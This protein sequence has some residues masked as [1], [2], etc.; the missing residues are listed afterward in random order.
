MMDLKVIALSN[1]TDEASE[2]TADSGTVKFLSEV[3]PLS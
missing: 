1:N 3:G 2:T